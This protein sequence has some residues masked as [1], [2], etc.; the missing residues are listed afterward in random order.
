ML[1]KRLLNGTGS[2]DRP[3]AG[4]GSV[5]IA[6]DSPVPQGGKKGGCC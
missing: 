6:D 3:A 4:R 1:E 2:S 5:I